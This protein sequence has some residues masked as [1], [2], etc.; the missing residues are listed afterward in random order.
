VF[1]NTVFDLCAAL[2][3]NVSEEAKARK[4]YY[5]L[6]ERYSDSFT[7]YEIEQLENIIAEELKHTELLNRMIRRR[8]G[9]VAEND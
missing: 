4:F 2:E 3:F 8:T 7:S 1:S 9:I 6:M 5:E